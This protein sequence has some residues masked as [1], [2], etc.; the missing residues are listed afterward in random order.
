MNTAE[1]KALPQ[2]LTTQGRYIGAQEAL[3]KELSEQLAYLSSTIPRTATPAVQANPT[4][5]STTAKPEKFN[6]E[7]SRC[8]GF[9]LQC[10]LCYAGKSH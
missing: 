2:A 9:L 4:P 1:V 8:W 3:I 10:T 7:T 5:S 6:E